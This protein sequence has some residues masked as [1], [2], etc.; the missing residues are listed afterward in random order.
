MENISI[1]SKNNGAGANADAT[2]SVDTT[3]DLEHLAR[4]IKDIDVAM[5]TTK[6]GSGNMRARPMGTLNG[7]GFDGT[8]YFFTDAGSPKVNEI[9]SD[10]QVNLTYSDRKSQHYVSVTGQARVTRDEKK[11]RELWNP[12]MK[13][14]FP[15]GLD[16]PSLALLEVEVSEAEY[17]DSPNSTVVQLVGFAKALLTGER[18]KAG[19]DGHVKVHVPH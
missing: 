6:D 5:L 13:A 9:E 7:S 17:W 11:I 3:R 8:L 15:K 14:W 12:I 19:K 10:H 1:N 2:Q 18:Y 4:L 16:D